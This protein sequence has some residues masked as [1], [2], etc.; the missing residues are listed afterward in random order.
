MRTAILLVGLSAVALAATP[1]APPGGQIQVQVNVVNVPVAVT[2]AEERFV[3]D[4]DKADF[5]VWEDGKPVEV[6]YFTRD[7]KQPLVVGF[8]LDASNTARLYVKT[9]QEAIT[10]LAWT[11]L[12]SSPAASRRDA[13]APAFTSMR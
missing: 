6:R 9:Y 1:Q 5:R 13:P 2:D 12:P 3:M 10:D 8:I 11:L 7:P 4:L